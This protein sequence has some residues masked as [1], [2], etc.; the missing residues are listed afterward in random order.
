MIRRLVWFVTIAVALLLP[1]FAWT[2]VLQAASQDGE[3][4]DQAAQDLPINSGYFSPSN[5]HKIKV[6]KGQLADQIEKGGGRVIA[7]YDNEALLEVDSQTAQ[8]LKTN[9]AV[10][11]RDEDN[12][13]LLNAGAIDTS[14][15]AGLDLQTASSGA[16]KGEKRMHLVQFAGPVRPEWYNS[17]VKTGVEV[18]TYIPNNAY[19]VYGDSG[20]LNRVKRLGQSRSTFIQWQGTYA[21]V[22]RMDPSFLMEQGAKAKLEQERDL[23]KNGGSL[24]AQGKPSEGTYDVQ[25]Y[26]DPKAN[27]KTMKL[28]NQIKTDAIKVQWEILD[29]ANLVVGLTDEGV[30]TLASRPDVVAILE[31]LTPRKLDERQD[32]IVSGNLSG[33][34]TPV[35]GLSWFTYLANQGFTQAQFDSS[36]FI[37]NI[38]DSGIDNANPTTP[39]NFAFYR[40]GDL[41]STSRLAYAR[42]IGTPNGGSTL[43]GCDGHGT[44]NGSIIMGFVPNGTVGSVDFNASPHVDGSGFHF[45]LGVCPFVKL[46]SS[47]IF[48]PNAF[49]NPNVTNLEAQ[50]YNDGSRISSNSWGNSSNTYGTFGQSYDALVRDAQP[51]S[52]T[53]PVAGNQEYVIVFAAGNNGPGANSVGQPG[54]AKNIITAGASENVQAFGGADGCGVPDSGADSALDVISFSSRGPTSD[55]RKK[56]DLMAPGTHVS[57]VVAQAAALATGTGAANACFTAGGV[58]GGPAPGF[59]FF[60][61][62]QQFYTA[63]SGT[64]HST[65]AIAGACALVRQF[66]IN[67]FGN[68]PSPAMTKASL[69][70]SASYMTGVGANDTLWSNVQGMGLMNVD[71]LFTTISGQNILRDQDAGDTFTASG[72]QRVFNATVADNT[73]PFRVT[74]AWT[75]APGPTSGNAFVNNLD[76]EVTVGGNTFKG[77]VFSGANS[78]TGGSADAA[79]NVESVFVP[80]GVSGPVLV[81]VLATNIAGDG[82]P[83]SGGALDQDFALVIA[84]AVPAAPAPFLVTA[85]STIVSEGCSPANG[86]ID[87]G[88]DVTVS[89]CLQNIGNA[90]TTGLVATLQATGGV[91]GPSGAQDYGVVVQGGAAVCRNFDFTASG[92]CGSTITA[93]LQLQDGATDLGTVTYTFTLGTL[94]TIFSENFDGVTA[95]ALPA[96]WTTS[97]LNGAANC[98]PTGTC[99][100][101]SNWATATTN[102][103]PSPPNAAFHH[104]VSCVTD[105]FLV[106]PAINIATA[107]AQLS[108][109]NAF[110]LENTFDGAVLEV[111]TD[112]GA[113]FADVTSGAIGGSFVSG[114][115][116]RTISN[117]FLSPI[118]G[119][120]AWSGLSG[121]ST[122]APSYLTTVVNL[123]PNVAGKTINLRWRVATDCSVAASGLNGH[124]V[125]NVSV[126]DGFV[127]STCGVCVP[128]ITC[129]ADITVVGTPGQSTVIVN[130]PPPTVGGGCSVTV[131][132]APASGSAFPLGTT[133]VTCTADSGTAIA[134][135]SFAITTFDV[136][137]QDDSNHSTNLLFNSATGAYQF[138]CGGT[139]YTGTGT[140]KKKGSTITLDDSGGNKRLSATVNGA[141]HSGKASL[142]SPVGVIRCSITDRDTRNNSC[143][144]P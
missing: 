144:C 2:L 43:Q 21:D 142:Q 76:L 42:L 94:N 54:T 38:S 26:K 5:R 73:K 103:P 86:A 139:T 34:T 115:Y 45:G 129:P 118:K 46:G 56:P 24:S 51:A 23:S 121:G 98:T 96:G 33:G 104:D 53:F 61:L 100:L 85:G 106:S 114:G 4:R 124:W 117:N 27:A 123:G 90:D 58:C 74:L 57:G 107:T 10:E 119:Q 44:E 30:K 127:C 122:T 112:G 130:Y 39:N 60:P 92:S 88:E 132:C 63:S 89:L 49:T 87:P 108:F 116:N 35:T 72:Q 143:S 141:T 134:T 29:Y 16:K 47:V 126:T 14:T 9:R 93:T 102:T 78:A 50:A 7:L 31:H 8:S 95:P 32:M 18:V 140:V 120:Q 110:N 109:S 133:T 12:L 138:C 1:S 75:D 69:M 81:R 40:S 55:G 128:T 70:N 111:S 83:N 68:P 22:Y 41:T 59:D 11:L 91:T 17:L 135:C 67:Q 19:L 66:F 84:N 131:T 64:S 105:N 82:V 113:T 101:G 25:L 80:A 99:A 52:S 77:N 20:S 13:I 65:P 3:V 48:D 97:F 36:N 62:G 125:D 137:L 15:G 79:N 136:C 6:A 71:Q 37:V 28:I